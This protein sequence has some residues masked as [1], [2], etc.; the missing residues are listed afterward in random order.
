M[1]CPL[2]SQSL[3]KEGNAGFIRGLGDMLERVK[4]CK[5]EENERFG[6]GAETCSRE[7]AGIE[8][9]LASIRY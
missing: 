4:D 1:R 5:I 3:Q 9:A 7:K 6:R 2:S 8:H